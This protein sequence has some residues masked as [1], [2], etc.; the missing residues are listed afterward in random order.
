LEYYDKE[1]NAKVKE[2]PDSLLK[3]FQTKNGRKVI[4]GRGIEPDIKVESP[5]LSRLTA[6]LLT[7]NCVFNYATDYVLAH[8]T[9]ATA[10][11]FKLSDE[12]YLDFQKYVLAQE[13]KYTTASE[14][15]LKKMKETAEKEG[16]FE[17]IKADY[18]DMISKVTPSKERD[19]Q[20]FKAEISEMLENEIISRYYF[21]K[22]RTVASLKNDIVVQRA[23]QVLTN[24]TEYN[25]ILKK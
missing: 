19:L 4:D 23:V 12:E 2:I 16:Y 7:S 11:D 14:E 9:V 1:N 15:S 6:V 13:F 18:E 20:K 10:A 17:E 25:T 8:P 24:S 21:Q 3:S 5:D 22:G